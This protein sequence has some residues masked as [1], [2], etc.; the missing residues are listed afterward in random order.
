MAINYEVRFSNHPEDA[1]QYGTQRLR[2]EFLVETLWLRVKS[3][4]S[5]P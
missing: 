1:K 3:T 4:W 2:E 5:I